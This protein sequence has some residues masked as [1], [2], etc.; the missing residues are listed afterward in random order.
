MLTRSLGADIRIGKRLAKDLWPAT[1]D[2][3]QIELA[4][5]NLAINARD[6]M[7]LGGSLII[8]SRNEVIVAPTADGLEAG[9][10]VAIVIADTGS[11]MPPDV[12]TR[13]LEPFFTTKDIGKGTGLGLSMVYGVMRQLAG[14]LR[15][16]SEVG[17]GTRVTLYLP[18]ARANAPIEKSSEPLSAPGPVSILLADG[19]PNTQAMV[20]A[21]AAE[22]GHTVIPA[23]TGAE[24]FA[25]LNS[26]RV[27]DIVIADSSLPGMS[28]R[29]LIGHAQARR[30]GLGALLATARPDRS[31]NAQAGATPT[32]AK[33][34]GRDA[35]NN[36][37]RTA[38]AQT[39]TATVIPLRRDPARSNRT[40][41]G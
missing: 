6:A 11:G 15:I 17:K 26:D 39:R 29:E 7:P 35:F 33:P 30:P 8:E 24:A 5:M 36:A 23:E 32:L 31:I 40:A 37:L 38:I 41:G 9:D 16:A 4:I 21:F 14:G 19:D 27:V 10:Y 34:F 12:L 28:G 25:I 1:A 22:L 2:R 3:N 13:V 20:A 18:R